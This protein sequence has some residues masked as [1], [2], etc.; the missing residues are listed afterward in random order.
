MNWQDKI[1]ES[2]KRTT[3]SRSQTSGPRYASDLAPGEVPLDSEERA[4][5]T[6]QFGDHTWGPQSKTKG[7]EQKYT[8]RIKGKKLT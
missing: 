3:R 6:N 8:K 4:G 2:I 5:R 1:Y 7:K